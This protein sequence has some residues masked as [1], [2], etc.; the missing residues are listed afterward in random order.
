MNVLSEETIEKH[1][2]FARQMSRDSL[3][4][5]KGSL[6]LREVNTLVLSPLPVS[7]NAADDALKLD[8]FAHRVATE[9]G[10]D[11]EIFD[12][13]LNVEQLQALIE[14]AKPYKQIIIGTYNVSMLKI[15][16]KLVQELL[17]IDEELVA[18]GLR[19]PYDLEFYPEVKPFVA[20]YEYSTL[21]VDSLVSAFKGE[22][23]F[24]GICPVKIAGV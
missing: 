15:Q 8:S 1:Q 19:N 2:V 5:V 6:N 9:L 17:Q 3:T 16:D 20:S 18:V 21:A 4:M 7:L 14:K 12:L 10:A 23:T 22:E 13:K 11:F 24:S